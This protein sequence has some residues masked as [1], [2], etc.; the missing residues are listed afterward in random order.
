MTGKFG[1]APLVFLQGGGEM[2]ELIRAFDWSRTPIGALES[3]SPALR[4]MVGTLVVNRFP[5]ML[6]WGPQYVNIY[7]DAYAPILG[8]KHPD[9]AL[10][11]PVSE[12]W[13]EIWDVLRP[14]IDAPFQGGPATWMEDIE[15]ELNRH[16]FPEETHFTVAYS[17]VPD[18]SAVGGIGGVLATVHEITQKVIGER[19]L[20]ALRDLG[21]ATINSRTAEEACRNSAAALAAHAKDLPFVLF[22]LIDSQRRSARLTVASGIAMGELFSPLVVELTESAAVGWPLA[23]VQGAKPLELIS[24][25]SGYFRTA[26][27]VDGVGTTSA[28]AAVLLPI[29]SPNR[30]EPFGFIVAGVSS[31]IPFD[32]LYGS[33]FELLA[34]QVSAAVATAEAYEQERKRAEALAELDRAKT[35]FFS[36]VSHEFRTPLT[37]MLGSLEDLVLGDQVFEPSV[38]ERIEMAQRNGQRLLRLVNSLLDF[39]RLESGR[40]QASFE[41]VDLARTTAELA[42]MFESAVDKAGMR[43]TIDCSPL[44][45]PIFVDRGMWEQIVLNLLSNAF[46]YTLHGDIVVALEE[47]DR[48]VV[49][50]VT[51][52]GVGIPE[53][54]LG[55]IFDRF[56]RVSETVGRTHEGTGIGLAMVKEL[57]VL[58]GGS[59]RVQS[60][61]GTGSRFEVDLP[62][63]RGHLPQ[64]NVLEEELQTS[65]RPSVSVQEAVHYLAPSD[66]DASTEAPGVALGIEPTRPPAARP[67]ILLADDNADMRRYVSR[68]LADKYD[69]LE[70]ADGIEA[71]RLVGEKHPHLVITDVMMPLLDGFQLV[72]KLRST[73][74]TASIPIIMLSARAGEES[75]IEG[76]NAG[77]DDYLVK[78]FSARELLARVGA[79]LE[80]AALRRETD[81]HIVRTLESINDGLITLD[82]QWR[83][84]YANG[85]ALRMIGRPSEELIGQCIWDLHP[86]MLGT[87]MES[88]LRRV[89]KD[90]ESGK[91]ESFLASIG[92]WCESKAYAGSNGGVTVFFHDVTERK[93]AQTALA[94]SERHKDEFLAT[95]AHEL[96]NPLAPLRAGL[97]VLVRARDK[98]DTFAETS[99]LMR[100]QLQHMVRLIDELLD[101]SRVSRGL[102]ELNNERV[103]VASLVQQATEMARPLLD[104]RTHTLHVVIPRDG[105]EVVGDTVRLCQILVNLL[106]N[107]AKY[108]E[109]GGV[110]TLTVEA[111]EAEVGIAVVD[112]GIGISAEALPRVFDMFSQ[113]SR[114]LD[115]TRGG[116]G[117]G[118]ALA[119]QLS[120]LHGGRIEA[121]SDGLR[122]GSRFVVWL[123]KAQPNDLTASP[124]GEKRSNRPAQR[125]LKILICDDN[126]DVAATMVSLLELFGHECFATYDGHAAIEYVKD[127]EP[128]LVFLD[129]GMPGLDGYQTCRRIRSFPAGINA[130][131]VAMTG[132]GS[133]EIQDSCT[134]TGFDAHVLKPPSLDRVQEIIASVPAR[135]ALA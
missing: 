110:I 98:P 45:E 97:E 17:P 88:T 100:R 16:G 5:M 41:P 40:V 23:A 1:S 94:D 33:F 65:T 14:L 85:E 61:L 113:V 70:A 28:T 73:P 102:I 66:R 103:D 48:R 116:L 115:A 86:E 51:D 8:S 125:P 6:W 27:V 55:K 60:T 119:R 52:T 63:G 127:S 82:P 20:L 77:A 11:L 36:N 117:I 78:P 106:N 87:E 22:Y 83:Y 58:H 2:A 84:T 129:I 30:Q 89:A 68:L 54:E 9:R 62:L 74:A 53:A 91:F 126:H 93:V 120:Q 130:T 46:K 15:L 128:D 47:R 19:R 25:L 99:E 56:H 131:I 39:A 109:P 29:R 96:R 50:S 7:N 64:A 90:G 118:L 92:R 107:A 26:A 24:D 49:F 79:R 38:R 34:T 21:A 135:R 72:E 31:R 35:M 67:I 42:N 121:K 95:L 81:E 124:A 75:R 80:L 104:E 32:A 18:Q 132:W 59:V 37:L 123:P 76:V 134:E 4:M 12:C 10:G 108:T 111:E 3:W 133:K 101:I 44:S 114:S 69:V 43:L 105:V 122:R 112:N 13:Q 57:A 71:I